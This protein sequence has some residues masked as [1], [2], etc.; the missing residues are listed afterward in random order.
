MKLA[1]PLT[2]AALIMSCTIAAAHPGVTTGTINLRAGPG[3]Q[4][5]IVTVIPVSQPISI[6]GCLPHSSWCD[7]AWAGYRGWVSAR[8][9]SYTATGHPVPV[10][11]VYHLVPEA[12]VYIHSHSAVVPPRAAARRDARIEYRVH[13]RIDRRWD[14]WTGD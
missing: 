6:I 9:I 13:R 7:V 2:L 8:Y 3:T 4:H 1:V 5:P 11:S 12:T 14:R 10:T